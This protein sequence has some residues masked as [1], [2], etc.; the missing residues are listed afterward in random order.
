MEPQP[1]SKDGVR[2]QIPPPGSQKDGDA[3][4]YVQETATADEQESNSG[5]ARLQKDKAAT[6]PR[7]ERLEKS[8][9]PEEYDGAQRTAAK[10]FACDDDAK[11]N[12][13]G[14]ELEPHEGGANHGQRRGGAAPN[15]LLRRVP[16]QDLDAEKSVLGAVLIENE[17]IGKVGWLG[18]R[19]FY[20]ETHRK[21]YE[22][23]LGLRATG[24]PIDTVTLPAALKA[25]GAF[26][27]TG[28]MG[29][30]A[31]LGASVPDQSNI[32]HYAAIVRDMSIKREIASKAARVASWAYDGVSVDTLVGEMERTLRLDTGA[33]L[34]ALI[35]GK[36][37]V[38][39]ALDFHKRHEAAPPRTWLVDGLLAKK[40]ISLW[41]GKVEAGKTTS[42]RTLVM[43]VL[44][45][46]PFFERHTYPS[47]VFYVMLD[48]DGEDGTFEGFQ[49]LG[50]NFHED[51][52]DFLIDPVM[53]IRPNSFEQFHQKLIELKPS[54]V[55]I[56][57]LGR[58]QKIDDITDYGTTYA[59]AKFSELAKQTNCH[60]ALLHHIPRGRSDADDPATAGFGSIA[61]A[62]GCNA[63]FVF[64]HKP[65][66]LYTVLSSKGK[67]GGFRPFE[68]EQ[69]LAMDPETGW[70]TISG[71]YTWK[72][73][74]RGIQPMV[75]A[76]I[77]QSDEWLTAQEIGRALGVQ[78]SIA[79]AA[80]KELAHLGDITL[81]VGKANRHYFCRQG[82]KVDL[83]K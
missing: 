70:V 41:S 37:E 62:G 4:G 18:A 20:R 42:L 12:G 61:I 73:Q 24:R 76:L 51:P 29:Y 36:I 66:D 1:D 67:G 38:I 9:P 44:R 83:P 54:L 63:R 46:E 78:R 10:Q 16:P 56:D 25:A 5:S 17:L 77:N 79:G 39:S 13:A 64:I 74:A 75:L 26:E 49:R 82:L 19:M 33:G 52:I 35:G 50:L 22:A 3:N 8:A 23:M 34:P 43:A 11:Q 65:G 31:D 14:Q 15:D 60:I 80:A 27:A 7:E 45:G 2:V 55:V 71:A 32:E 72:E 68:G 69:T 59:M 21:I 58:F 81:S 47:R 48:A 6:G 53:A 57:P 28:G 40:E 30:I